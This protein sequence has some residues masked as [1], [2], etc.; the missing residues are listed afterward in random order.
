MTMPSYLLIPELSF[1]DTE[2]NRF[3]SRVK[4]P[5]KNGCMIWVGKIG[6]KDNRYGQFS[7]KN[8]KV[9][10]AHRYSYELYFGKI[11]TGLFVLHTCDTPACVCPDHL[12]IG[13]Q[14]DNAVD[15]RIKNRG[16]NNSGENHGRA[17][18]TLNKVRQIRELY[19]GA[20]G[21]IKELSLQFS[22]SKSTI[23]NIVNN[24]TWRNI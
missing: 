21:E 20:N 10:T 13:T 17:I 22:V 6:K 1:P 4:I 11:P 12:F 15:M 2:K 8:K 23:S 24:K 14:H 9:L 5:N 16:F 18:L 3:Y 7:S 19:T